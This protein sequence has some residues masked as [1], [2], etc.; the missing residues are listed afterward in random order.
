MNEF[1]LM[2]PTKPLRS[3]FVLAHIQPQS[4][5]SKSSTLLLLIWRGGFIREAPLAPSKPSQAR[6][7]SDYSQQNC[8]PSP[9]LRFGKD[10]PCRSFLF[11]TPRGR[12]SPSFFWI[13][14]IARLIRFFVVR[15]WPPIRCSVCLECLTVLTMQPILPDDPLHDAHGLA[16]LSQ[17]A[18]FL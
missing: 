1:S 3:A 2:P 14:H 16:V 15:S 9:R 6:A 5:P 13:L 8:V 12:L 18:T 11:C 7:K 17:E 4:H 10:S